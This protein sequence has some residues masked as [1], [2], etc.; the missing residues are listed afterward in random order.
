MNM[1]EEAF[2]RIMVMRAFIERKKNHPFRDQT[3]KYPLTGR[4]QD[5]EQKMCGQDYKFSFTNN[6]KLY[7]DR[8]DNNGASRYQLSPRPL[9][10][11]SLLISTPKGWPTDKY[12]KNSQKKG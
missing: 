4:K 6:E 7:Q 8:D 3:E 1:H 9:A 2:S 12:R 10:S 5:Q 11:G